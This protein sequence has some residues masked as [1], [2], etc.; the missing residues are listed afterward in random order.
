MADDLQALEDWVTPM[1]A[2]LDR[3]A[4]RTLAR[5]VAQDLR[6]A[7]RERIKAQQNP[8][9]TP[10]APRKPQHRAQQ[11]AIRR[12]TM[13]TKIRTAKYLKARGTAEGAEVGFVGRVAHIARVH[14]EGLRARVDRDGPRV[15]YP[16]RRLL[17]LSDADHQLIQDSVLRHLTAG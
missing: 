16:E 8:D 4:R 11:G 7:Q 12:R 1:L 13:F 5:K 3:K 6:R 17:G 10:Y 2:Q 15:S 9:G 14:Q